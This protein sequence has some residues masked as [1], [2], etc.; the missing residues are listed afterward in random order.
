MAQNPGT[1]RQLPDHA[2]LDHFGKQ[3]YLGNGYSVIASTTSAGTAEVNLMLL[4]N[5][6]VSAS[7][8]P[9]GYESLF[10]NLKA[11]SSLTASN[12]VIFRAYLN[13]TVTGAGTP[14][15]PV[16]LRTG[17]AS[18]SIAAYST[19]PTTSAP[20]TLVSLFSAAPLGSNKDEGLI[21]LDPGKS[22]LVTYQTSA[23][24]TALAASLRWNEI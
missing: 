13:P 14:G 22:L 21:I 24:A 1:N 3:T 20:G 8:F 7:A 2:I 12:S 16:Q 19:A 5:P 9:N 10:V 17:N 6:G 4:S 18:T 23:T 11:I 15:V